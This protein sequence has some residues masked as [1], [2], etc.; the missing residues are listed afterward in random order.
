MMQHA[1][2]SLV[3]SNMNFRVF[4]SVMAASLALVASSRAFINF[5]TAPVHPIALSPDGHTLAV[6]NLPDGRIELFN[7]STGVPLPAGNVPVGVDP[8]SLRFRDTNELWVVN[9]ISS[10]VNIVDV[11]RGQVTAVLPTFAGPADVVFAGN[12]KRAFVSCARSNVVMVFDPQTRALLASVAID[13]EKPKAMAV[14]PDGSKVYVAI[15]ESGNGSTILG[16][17]LTEVAFPDPSVVDYTNGPYHGQNPPPNN[18]NTFSPPLNPALT[19]PPSASHIVKKNSAGRWLDGNGGDWTEFVS[20]TNAANSGRVPGWNLPDHDLAV[21]DTTSLSVSYVSGLMNI[22]MDVAVNPVS[23][24]IAMAGTDATNERRFEPN[25]QS[26]FLR[27]NLALIDPVTRTNM[28]KDL[29]PH[30]DYVVRRIPPSEREKSLGDPRGVVWSADGARCYVGGMG[31]GNLVVL[32]AKGDRAQAQPIPL[33]EGTAGLC[34]DEARQR[35]YVM[36]RFSSTVSVVDLSSLTVTSNVAFFDPTPSFIKA[37]RRLLYDTHDSS[38]LGYVSCASC[39][40]D[41][42]LDRLA[43]DLGNPSGDMITNRFGVF[44]PMKGP[45]ITQTLQALNPDGPLHWRADRDGIL[46]F[47]QTFVTLLG[48]ET[49]PDSYEMNALGDSLHSIFFPPNPLRNFDNTLST[50]VPLPGHYAFDE[51]LGAPG[52]QPL[53]NGDAFRG[54]AVLFRSQCGSCHN[55]GSG[56]GDATAGT[57]TGGLARDFGLQFKVAQLRSLADKVGFDMSQPTSRAGFGFSHDG[58]ADTLTRFLA[59]AFGDTTAQETAD[60]TAFLLSFSGSDI[61]FT[62]FEGGEDVESNLDAP[63][64]LGYQIL[65]TN[66]ASNPMLPSMRELVESGTTRLALIA[67]GMKNGIPRSWIYDAQNAWMESDRDAEY[68]SLPDLVQTASPTNELVFMLVARDSGRRIAIDR[69]DDGFSD[70]TERDFGLDPWDASSRG[71]NTPLRLLSNYEPQVSVHSEL[72]FK[73]QFSVDSPAEDGDGCSELAHP[74]FQ[75]LGAVPEGASINPTNGQFTWTPTAAQ[76]MQ[77]HRFSVFVTDNEAP[78]VSVAVP[79]QIDVIGPVRITSILPQVFAK[80]TWINW[81]AAS[82]RNYRIDYRDGWDA[83]EWSAL[84]SYWLGVDNTWPFPAR[85]FYRLVLLP[86]TD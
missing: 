65:L 42:R 20:G 52:R 17:R 68:I 69:D 11:S 4:A 82:G 53:P 51:D 34:L 7:V 58:R 27:V 55:P 21:I 46:E 64:A 2:T 30:L 57:L 63:A 61:R 60:L 62:S 73:A 3:F 75:L 44:H 38:G 70:Q 24:L 54:G 81:P 67:R 43:W 13:G 29:N 47:A 78:P 36:N 9:F 79:F 71:A 59:D 76:S 41:G 14:S 83:L 16:G 86:E 15:F 77:T 8:V 22:C 85:R 40:V 31:S 66:S 10:S 49:E 72:P 48:R 33:Q 39:H 32:D 6:C 25:L 74:T 37:G 12:P 19:N 84:P 45:K 35:L 23:G 28:I 1:P 56:L 80:R 18:G 5:E 50:N 26:T